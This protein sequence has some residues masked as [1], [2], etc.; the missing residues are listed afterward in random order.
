MS[1]R[2]YHRAGYPALWVTTHEQARAVAEYGADLRADGVRTFTWDVLDGVW[3]LNGGVH[4]VERSAT[5][6]VAALD[7]LA[8]DK[9]PEPAALFAS[10]AHKFAGG[11]DVQQAIL[12]V[13]PALKA[14]RMKI[15]DALGHV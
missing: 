1:I 5:D 8:S 4:A 3:E 13:V 11:V 2:D 9:A 12:R 14:S 15:V 7:W 6:L 10:L